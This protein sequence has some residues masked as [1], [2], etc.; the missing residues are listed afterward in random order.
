MQALDALKGTD[1]QVV[2][3]DILRGLKKQVKELGKAY[4][5]YT[6]LLMKEKAAGNLEKRRELLKLLDSFMLE[7]EDKYRLSQSILKAGDNASFEKLA[8]EIA[9]RGRI[10]AEKRMK[11]IYRERIGNL[12]KQS[13]PNKVTQQRYDYENNVLFR[14][15]REYNGLTREE[16]KERQEE[17][18]GQAPYEELTEQEKIRYRF[19]EYKKQGME[20]SPSLMG[21]VASDLSEAMK[22]G[23]AAK[24]E[25]EF[26][27]KMERGEEVAQ[28]LAALNTHT[29]KAGSL[30]TISGNIY[31]RGVAN[32]WS[33]LNSITNKKTADKYEFETLQTEVDTRVFLRTQEAINKAMDVFGLKKK[34]LMDFFVQEGKEEEGFALTNKKTQVSRNLS[35][36]EIMDIYNA[37]KN[38]KVREDYF[39]A[40][41]QR[42]VEYLVGMLSDE[43]KAFADWMRTIAQ[44][45]YD[46]YN[47]VYIQL[48]GIDLK[49]AENYWPATSEHY[50][51]IQIEG[52]YKNQSSVPS[53]LKE[54]ARGRVVPVPK[55]AWEKY[56]RH[57]TQA[58]YITGLGLDYMNVKRVFANAVIKDTIE[59][60][61][62][63]GVYRDL[64]EDIETLSLNRKM[65]TIDAANGLFNLIRNNWVV[66]KIGLNVSVFLKQL[67]SLINY[68]EGMPADVW[69][70]YFAEGI[71]HPK[72]TWQEMTQEMPFIQARIAQGNN[73]AMMRAMQSDAVWKKKG[74]YTQAM[75]ALTRYGDG[76]AVIYGGYPY[77]RWL[78]EQGDSEAARKFE[79][80][81]LRSQQS[82]AAV[83]LS[84]LQRSRGKLSL[85]LAFK[86]ASM[87]F[88]RKMTDATI[89]FARGEIT[90]SQYAKIMFL[91]TVANPVLVTLAGV[92]AGMLY[93][94]S[95]DD[96]ELTDK[97]LEQVLL[98]PVEGYIVASDM[99]RYAY[100]RATGQPAYNVFSTPVLDDMERIVRSLSKEE[101]SGWDMAQAAWNMGGMVAALPAYPFNVAK[102]HLKEEKKK[103]KR[104]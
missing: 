8:S 65:E 21:Q 78:K 12:L 49:K 40:Y 100:R 19:L 17:I 97:L 91:Y 48:Y 33:L 81:T 79:F 27:K 82:G 31:R 20:S 103:K 47:V 22:A 102:S 90:G 59:K 5:K 73:E 57:F 9:R 98:N 74:S 23:R 67:T 55:N 51:P 83:S 14:D 44:S 70:K 99:A 76:F 104:K 37:I 26:A 84:P 53:A 32:L 36:M 72:Q 64:M 56:A 38:E 101:P 45:F 3:E 75:T 7:G 4:E 85:F 50:D 10:Y 58:E 54:R 39:E 18:F 34:D 2:D 94:G 41:G 30:R 96:D 95:D 88:T 93:G 28:V 69:A 25:E 61:F 66:S 89:N 87:Q 68:M 86:N 71:L 42:Q 13:K 46:K 1:K 43:E 15:L 77:Y 16:A 6:A 62:G 24:T 35:R 29:N 52:D 80:A 92:A 63:K 11:H 60:K